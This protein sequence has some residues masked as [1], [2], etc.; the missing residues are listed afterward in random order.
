[1]L[2]FFTSAGRNEI[3]KWHV[4][5]RNCVAKGKIIFAAAGCT[6]SVRDLT[7]CST[8]VPPTP[9]SAVISYFV[10]YYFFSFFAFPV[11]S[12]I[13]KNFLHTNN[14]REMDGRHA[15]KEAWC[16][17]RRKGETNITYD[18]RCTE[19]IFR[20]SNSLRTC[21]HS[22][23]NFISISFHFDARSFCSS[24]TKCL[25]VFT[26]ETHP[27]PLQL[28]EHNFG[29]FAFCWLFVLKW[30]DT[31]CATRHVI[32]I[33]RNE[34]SMCFVRLPVSGQL[35]TRLSEQKRTEKMRKTYCRN[36]S[37]NFI[38][39][40]IGRGQFSFL[41]F[42]IPLGTLYKEIIHRCRSFR[43]HEGEN[44]CKMMALIDRSGSDRIKMLQ[45]TWRQHERQVN[46]E[47]VE[48]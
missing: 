28:Q 47:W 21:F 42:R 4:N 30:F 5:P 31:W 8:L 38:C 24:Q 3:K 20:R 41:L 27:M 9:P 11:C 29:H 23:R 48:Q 14:T 19:C 32:S 10:R 16:G 37:A 40:R 2:H 12:R 35:P 33:I 44:K 34:N 1:M 15:D 13:E 18:K 39:F 26:C 43:H 46:M 7:R 22:L 36:S 6:E 45:H 25:H 17:I